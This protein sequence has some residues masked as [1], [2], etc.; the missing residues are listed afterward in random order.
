[1][2]ER[3]SGSA[4][5]SESVRAERLAASER[6]EPTAIEQADRIRFP[7]PIALLIVGAIAAATLLALAWPVLP[8]SEGRRIVL[9]PTKVGVI[10]RQI[11]SSGAAGRVDAPAPD[12]EWVAPDGSRVSL[13]SLRPRGVVI[14]FWATWCEPCKREM[15]L[16]DRIAG[17]TP[18]VVFLAVDMDEDGDRIRSF[19]DQ[20]GIKR[21]EPL[22]DVGLVTTHRYGVVSV[23]STFFVDGG[24][25]IR[26]M[27]V[28]EMSEADLRRGVDRI[29]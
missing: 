28:G 25:T 14:N 23:P 9:G 15:P 7:R 11:E 13:S 24:G 4:G 8:W 16:M 18:G 20:V 6:S 21:L 19:F 2:I 10:V 29:K 27:K 1:M 22:L 5:P 12:F 17:G 3:G 26:H